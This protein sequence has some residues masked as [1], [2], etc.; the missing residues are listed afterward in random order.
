MF[1]NL[2]K[3]YLELPHEQNQYIFKDLKIIDVL[4][5]ILCSLFLKHELW[6][7]KKSKDKRMKLF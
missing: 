4:N 2:L 3:I 6:K 1:Y 7:I 5:D